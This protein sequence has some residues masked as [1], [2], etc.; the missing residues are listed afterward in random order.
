MFLIVGL[1]NPGKFY[2]NNRHNIGYKIIDNIR[3]VYNFPDFTKKFKSEFSKSELNKNILFLLKPTTFMNNSGIAL[4]EIKDFYNIN[5]NNIYV[6]HD[7]IDL[8]QGLVKVKNGGGHNGHNGLKSI[9][10]HI[11][12]N[13]NRVRVGIS[14]PSKI[15][16]E[17]VNENISNWVLSDFTSDEKKQW[18]DKT[19][20]D[21]SD[22]VVSLIMNHSVFYDKNI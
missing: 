12:K 6:I 15:F 22:M 11:G 20:F 5:I 2:K 4:K 14:R 7:E 10:S 1:G 17:N 21:V 13:Y 18:L 19:I 16:Q 9:D 8:D 3:D